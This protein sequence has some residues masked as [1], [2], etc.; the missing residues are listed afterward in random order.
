MQ[1]VKKSAKQQQQ[2]RVAALGYACGM[3][4]ACGCCSCLATPRFIARPRRF[5]P[6]PA[7]TT[8]IDSEQQQQQQQH[9][10]KPHPDNSYSSSN[11]N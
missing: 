3:D 6:E 2:Q 1:L 8:I 11:N 5:M 9:P 10:L 7:T 4:C